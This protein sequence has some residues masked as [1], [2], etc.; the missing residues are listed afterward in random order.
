MSQSA[1]KVRRAQRRQH[2]TDPLGLDAFFGQELTHCDCNACEVAIFQVGSALDGQGGEVIPAPCVRLQAGVFGK[3]LK[4]EGFE[5]FFGC[6]F[7][8]QGG[9][10]FLDT[11]LVFRPA[12]GII[13]HLAC[14]DH[15][16]A[17]LAGGD[18]LPGNQTGIDGSDS[19]VGQVEREGATL[20]QVGLIRVQA[21]LAGSNR[22]QGWFQHEL[23]AINTRVQDQ[24]NV[25]RCVCRFFQ[26]CRSGSPQHRHRVRCDIP[27]QPDTLNSNSPRQPEMCE[28]RLTGMLNV[29]R[30]PALLRCPT[31][32]RRQIV[33]RIQGRADGLS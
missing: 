32:S 8:D 16:G 6:W 18:H 9:S 10:G 14:Q 12:P 4:P 17:D 30:A 3:G 27:C 26:A 25:L 20:S 24:A 23:A 5:A 19:A 11:E 22:S 28:T 2:Q 1:N 29:F 13:L 15:G 21:Q 7:Q 33:H 31:P